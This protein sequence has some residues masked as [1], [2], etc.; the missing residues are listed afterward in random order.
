MDFSADKFGACL[1]TETER[2]LSIL[3]LNERS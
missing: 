1:V 2:M 3:R